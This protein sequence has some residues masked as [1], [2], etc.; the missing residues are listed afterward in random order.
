MS[1][2]HRGRN[3]PDP[4]VADTRPP[5]VDELSKPLPARV[6][7]T[8][9]SGAWVGICATVLGFVVLIVFMLQNTGSVAINFLWMNGSVPLALAL[10]IAGVA[11]A[12]LAIAIG[13]AR[14]AQ[15][16]RLV[17]RGKS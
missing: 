11:T 8:R 9:V 12:V 3:T 17:R 16:R 5:A 15:L 14:M 7:R 6:P 4:P 10:F 2:L 13:T 1:V